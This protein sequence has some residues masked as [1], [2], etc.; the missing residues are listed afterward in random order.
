MKSGEHSKKRQSRLGFA[1]GG[2]PPQTWEFNMRKLGKVFFFKARQGKAEPGT[3]ISMY[4]EFMYARIV[5][6][7]DIPG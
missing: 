4:P 5:L 2:I 1:V 7:Q 3:G 6:C